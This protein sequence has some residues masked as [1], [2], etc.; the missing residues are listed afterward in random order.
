MGGVNWSTR[1]VFTNSGGR[2]PYRGPWNIESMAREQMMDA[3]A[4]VSGIDPVELRRR[5]AVSRA[6]MPFTNASGMRYT[7]IDPAA[8]LEEALN[9]SHY[10]GLRQEQSEQRD[11]GRRLGVGVSLFVEP[12]AL[13]AGSMLGT[14]AAHVRVSLAGKVTV[15]LGTSSHG[16]SIAT[17][18]AQIA[19]DELGVDLDDVTVVDGETDVTPIGG[20]TG[21]SRSAVIGGGATHRA[22][23]SVREKV[24]AVAAEMMEAAP[25]D[26][27][28]EGGR[29]HV[30]GTPSR[31]VTLADVAH[32]AYMDTKSLPP[33]MEA[34]LE[35]LVRYSTP[36]TTYANA[37]HVCVV[38]ILPTGKCEILRYVVVEDCGAMINPAVVHGQISGGVVQGIGGVL[39]ER[40]AYDTDGNPLTTTFMD[41]L[42][43][44]STEIPFIEISH[45]NTPAQGPGGYKGVGEGGAIG[46][47]PAVRNAISD[48]LG[49]EVTDGVRPCDLFESP[50]FP[51]APSE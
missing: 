27:E 16:Q 37:C 38:E 22:A 8:V 39:H 35:A 5:N 34:G 44:T 25:E 45:L 42:L 9:R 19:A 51:I 40:F 33:G 20:G 6:D 43:P 41:Y 4:R 31:S 7:D 21:G 30:Q 3:A 23:A 29:I 15:A 12:T 2:T 1:A 17:T 50:A 26:L 13:G 46:A 24:I 11:A 32:V 48:A 49:A 47:V 36:A 28:M 18:M 14:E 10:A